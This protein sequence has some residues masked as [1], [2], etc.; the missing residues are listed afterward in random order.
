[1]L[2]PQAV[3]A[4]W[5]STPYGLEASAKRREPRRAAPAALP[6]SSGQAENQPENGRPALFR[7]P[8]QPQLRNGA[9]VRDS[10]YE[11]LA[12]PWTARRIP[13]AAGRSRVPQDF[14]H[15]GT[16][17]REVS[18]QECGAEECSSPLPRLPGLRTGDRK[19]ERGRVPAARVS[20]SGEPP[21]SHRNL[22]KIPVGA[23]ERAPGPPPLARHHGRKRKSLRPRPLLSPVR[24][25]L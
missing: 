3:M 21:R 18:R 6:S 8:V 20:A 25:G 24:R 13:V 15:V 5:R 23:P 14:N 16:T 1:M 12:P 9:G 22:A 19:H 7:N 11:A 2:L 10:D 4:D 17:S